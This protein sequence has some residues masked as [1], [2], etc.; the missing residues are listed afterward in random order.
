M[1]T[2]AVRGSHF[3][4][5]FR[6]LPPP[7]RAALHAVYAFCRVADDAVDEASDKTAAQGALARVRRRLDEAYAGQPRPEDAALA[8]AASRYALPKGL[9]E[10]LLEGVSWDLAGR[11]YATRAELREYAW[12]VASTVGLMCVRIFGR[13]A[14]DCDRWAEELGIALQWTN[15]LRDV[16]TD[17][18]RG[19]IYLPTESLDRHGVTAADLARP[20]GAA[21]PRL[22]ALLKEEAAFAGGRFDAAS[23][24]L[25]RDARPDVLAGEIMAAVYR[26]L[27]GRL[28]R[29]GAGALE[30]PIRIPAWERAAVAG[31]VIA[32]DRWR[33][34]TGR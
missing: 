22:D 5:A 4:V 27:L 21:R 10:S 29:A 23:R 34:L 17:L 14:G 19:R 15:I 26:R 2:R 24:A 28:A 20:N 11:R 18:R 12:R 3:R 31:A 33:R 16:G 32:S 25:P 7:R 8:D 30:P 6:V 9:F 13:G 1:S